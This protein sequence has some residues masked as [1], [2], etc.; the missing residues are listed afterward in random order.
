MSGKRSE[1][2]TGD[3]AT[4]SWGRVIISKLLAASCG[5]IRKEYVSDEAISFETSVEAFWF[6]ALA[7][8]DQARPIHG[9]IYIVMPAWE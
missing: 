9:T 2:A 6:K 8:G 4:S 3:G 5:R 7:V 1:K